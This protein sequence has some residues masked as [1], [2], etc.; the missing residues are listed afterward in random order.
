MKSGVVNIPPDDE[1]G[2]KITP[3]SGVKTTLY[4]KSKGKGA[5]EKEEQRQTQAS[6]SEVQGLRRQIDLK[7]V[8]REERRVQQTKEITALRKLDLRRFW[9]DTILQFHETSQPTAL[10]DKQVH[11]LY[12]K[13]K[14]FLE[15]TDHVESFPAFV[16]WVIENWKNLMSTVFHWMTG[17]PD[18]PDIWFF[19]RNYSEFYRIFKQR[20]R[21]WLE[22]ISGK[23]AE[24]SAT[25]KEI[26]K[27]KEEK[28]ALRLERQMLENERG[29]KILSPKK[30]LSYSP[31]SNEFGKFKWNDEEKMNRSTNRSVSI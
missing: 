10:S 7:R 6:A 8:K 18:Q 1:T 9:R 24:P 17:R 26:R 27:L 4:K 11:A 29:K 20:D 14:Q 30:K 19:L 31:K 28:K 12:S 16:E 13:Q 2:V 21:E 3:S 25:E 5:K 22:M 23:E 15:A